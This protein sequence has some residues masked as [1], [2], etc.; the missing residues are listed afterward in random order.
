M[1][2][3]GSGGFAFTDGAFVSGTPIDET[4]M[5]NKFADV[6]TTLAASLAK[7]GQTTMTGDL[8][9]GGKKITGIADGVA[10]TDVTS[11]GHVQKQTWAWVTSVAGT[12]DAITGNT[13]PAPTLAAGMAFRILTTAA[14]TTAVTLALNGGSA[15]AVKKHGTTALAA[16]DVLSGQIIEVVYDGT[17]FQLTNVRNVCGSYKFLGRKTGG[18]Q[19]TGG[20][21]EV[22]TCQ[23]E[24][25][26]DGANFVHTTG[27]FTAP[28]TGTY[29]LNVY[30]ECFK[31]GAADNVKIV[32]T[33]L[34]YLLRPG[35]GTT[36]SWMTFSQMV[37]L[38]AGDTAKVV[39]GTSG[40]IVY[41][42]NFTF[43]GYLVGV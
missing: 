13:S 9:M 29:M 42:E 8:L 5:N 40:T 43:S 23:T 26:D 25:Y 41:D 21:D 24:D 20:A 22:V 2:R 16:N 12:G 38:T 19:T 1:P 3:N 30:I 32:T 33:P 37:K 31:S 27:I 18:D 17:N 14:N 39:I 7:D 6:A 28:V 15:V 4:V 11:L 10:V 35:D 36:H 34:T